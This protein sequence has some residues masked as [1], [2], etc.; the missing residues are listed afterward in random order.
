M[1]V[2][3]G[4]AGLL[5]A[6]GAGGV[7]TPDEAEGAWNK[8]ILALMDELVKKKPKDISLGAVQEGVFKELQSRNP[9]FTTPEYVMKGHDIRHL[10]KSRMEKPNPKKKMSVDEIGELLNSL[11]T[12]TRAR[13]VTGKKEYPEALLVPHGGE[14]FLGILRPEGGKVA[15]QTAYDP[16]TNKLPSKLGSLFHE[17][18]SLKDWVDANL[19][20]NYAPREGGR[21]FTQ[22]QLSAV[23]PLNKSSLVK[24]TEDV[25][26]F[27]PPFPLAG[28][29]L[30]ASI[31]NAPA[32]QGAGYDWGMED[33]K[34]KLLKAL[35]KIM[36]VSQQVKPTLQQANNWTEFEREWN[37]GNRNITEPGLKEPLWSPMDLPAAF[38]GGAIGAA[39]K[40]ILTGL[41]AALMDAPAT[42]GLGWGIENMERGFELLPYLPQGYIW[43]M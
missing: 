31:Y 21:E 5:A 34:E 17:K 2:I 23:E 43:G 36:K 22:R 10:E 13:T 16:K 38:A 39:G 32:T 4:L 11:T 9:D 24:D 25:K 41:G 15:F 8:N 3:K 37:N 26:A 33:R 35:E 28:G 14:S 42:I 20:S 29:L 27:L 7:A 6:L 18:S 19:P 1:A 40:P 30:T 12:S